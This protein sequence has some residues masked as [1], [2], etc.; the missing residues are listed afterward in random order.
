MIIFLLIVIVLI[1]AIANPDASATI[2]G[3]MLW[4]TF[5]ILIWGG[6][7]AV[8]VGFIFYVVNVVNI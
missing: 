4:L 8:V 3:F 6:L 2:V 1:L 5:T 7:L